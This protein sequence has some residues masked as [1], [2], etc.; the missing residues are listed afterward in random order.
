MTVTSPKGLMSP[1]GSIE[2]AQP[3]NPETVMIATKFIGLDVHKDT[4]AVA[5]ADDSGEREVRFHGTIPNTPDALRRFIAR[6][7]G[8]G[9]ELRCCYEAGAC[10]YGIYRQLKRLGV[11]CIVI[12]PS[13]RP[14]RPGERVKTDRR[15]AITLARLLRAGELASVWVPDE[16]HEAVRDVV[17]ARRQAKQDLT[18]AKQS[19]LSFLLRQERRFSGR[20]TWSRAHWRWL[21][22]QAFASPHQQLVF[23]EGIRRIE[24]AQ[25]R[26][27]RLDLAL[28]EAV[29]GW[30]L[31]P[32]VQALQA[33]R[34]IGL[35]V[36]A[37][38]VAEIGDLSRF[39]TPKQLMSWL[40]LVPSEHSSGRRTRRGAIT[41]SGNGHARSMLAEA[42]WSY[43]H[44]AREERR[45]RMRLEGL[46]EEIRAIGWRAQV[47]LCQR[48]R[49]LMAMGKPLPKVNTAIARELAGFVWDVARRVPAVP[50]AVARA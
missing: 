32:L 43:R 45:Y 5:V 46:P 6:L 1:E 25:A 33:L 24:E 18:A 31:A 48:F 19:L 3:K 26:C 47:R 16:G 42:S 15:D 21:G 28:A 10:G 40:G 7:S 39:E 4:L 20:S 35:V 23:G 17:R 37:T 49:H 13:M 38:L 9:V 27:D 2:A 12:A 11:A 22:E 30:R 41:K 8:P 34:G 36:A 44:P 29:A 50:A 14:R